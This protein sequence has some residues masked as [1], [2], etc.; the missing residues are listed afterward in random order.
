MTYRF[1]TASV[2]AEDAKLLLQRING[3]VAAMH[4]NGY[5]LINF[6]VV[7]IK[8]MHFEGT[9]KFRKEEKAA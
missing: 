1:E 7:N 6:D 8:S 2:V 4:R 5:D 3:T 9:M